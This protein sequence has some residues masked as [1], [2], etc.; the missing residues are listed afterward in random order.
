[1]K[2][3]P[4]IETLLNRDKKTSKV[5]LG[6]WR[7]PEFEYLKDCIWTFTEK[8][9]GTNIRIMWDGQKVTF[10]G[11]TNNA[12]IPAFLITK[13]QELFPVD[14]FSIYKDSMCLYGEGY[15]ARIQKGGGNY[16]SDGVNFVL[17]DVKVGDWWLRRDDVVDVSLK[18]NIGLIPNVG[19]GTLIQAIE[20]TQN[21][22]LSKYGNFQAEGIVIRPKV[23]L[24]T[25]SGHRLIGKIKAKDF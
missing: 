22:F 20:K 8:V 21:G 23:E 12:Q 5:I 19:E 3:Y 13:L 14:K 24:M 2:E 11:K 1:M 18:L 10:G 7:L 9:D 15:G 16:I 17:F 4:K 25:R 6:E